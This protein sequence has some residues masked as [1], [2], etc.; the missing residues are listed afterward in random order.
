MKNWPYS[1]LGRFNQIWQLTIYEIQNFNH[2][3]IFLATIGNNGQ[4]CTL[5]NLIKKSTK[6]KCEV[7]HV[8]LVGINIVVQSRTS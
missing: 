7:G 2:I 5:T 4:L 6:L 3:Y 8:E 1:S